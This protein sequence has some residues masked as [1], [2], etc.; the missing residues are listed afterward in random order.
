ML[1]DFLIARNPEEGTTL[2][3]LLRIPLGP[4]GIVLKAKETWPRTGKVYCHR[5]VGWPREPEILERVPVRSCVRRGAAIDLVLDR[6]RENR[7]QFVLTRVRGGREAI[8]WQTARTSKQ[9]RPSVS[10]PTA[11]GWGVAGLE[12][13]VDSHER[14]AWKFEHQQAT[15]VRRA[16]RSGDYAV[17]AGDQVVASVERKSLQDLVATL[18]SGKMRYL[19]ADLATLPSAAV[20]VEDRYSAVFKLDRVRPATVADA[21]GEC[22]ARFP[23]VPVVFCET[24]ALAQEWT[25]RFLAAALVHAGETVHAQTEASPLPS[26]AAPSPAEV[27]VW[28]R[29]QG[30]AVSDR[31]RIPGEVLD[32]FARRNG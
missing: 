7:S 10:L 16:L 24:R 8:F 17:L 26:A 29:Q 31:G 23:G 14:Y 27:R 21:L 13:V 22:Q 18:T 6:G 11:R 28:A 30:Y 12:I 25:Y 1:D 3:F 9:A 19:L 5:A 15:T 2:P 4:D 20:V 32:A